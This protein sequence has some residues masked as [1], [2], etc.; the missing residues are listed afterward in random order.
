MSILANTRKTFGRLL[1][2]AAATASLTALAQDP[3]KAELEYYP[4]V[5]WNVGDHTME[6]GGVE[7]MPDGRVMIV[8]R[9]GEMF[10]A[11]NPMDAN[12]KVTYKPFA[13]G[14]AQPLGVAY[15][16][17][18]YYVAQRGE[19]TRIVD[20]DGDDR[21]DVFETVSDGWE[22][23]GSYHEYNFGPRMG[24][25]GQF[26]VTLNKPFGK[27]VYGR[28]RWRGWAVRVSLDG[29]M[30]GMAMGLRSPAGMEFSPWGELFYTDNQ[31]EWCNASKLSLIKKDDFHGHPHS[32]PDTAFADSPIRDV[33]Q[34]VSGTPMNDVA[35]QI[36]RWRM[37]AVWL[38]YR[39]IGQSPAG[40]AWDQSKG[41]FGPFQGQ[42]FVGDQHSSLLMRVALEKVN[43]HWQGAAFHHRKGLQC[44]VIRV[45]QLPDGSML[46]GQSERGWGALGAAPFGLQR[47]MWSGK[48]PFEMHEVKARPDGFEITFTQ[49]VSES[50]AKPESWKIKSYTYLLRKN[51]GGP[52]ENV[53][54]LTISSAKLAA[55]RKSVRLF[56][57]GLRQG[58]VHEIDGTGVVNDKGEKLLHPEAWYTLAEIP[59]E[60]ATL[61]FAG[62]KPTKGTADEPGA[63]EFATQNLPAGTRGGVKLTHQNGEF[64][65]GYQLGGKANVTIF[66]KPLDLTS[67]VMKI[68]GT[69]VQPSMKSVDPKGWNSVR[70]NYQRQGGKPMLSRVYINQRLIHQAVPLGSGTGRADVIIN[71]TGALKISDFTQ[72]ATQAEDVSTKPQAKPQQGGKKKPGNNKKQGPKKPATLKNGNLAHAESATITGDASFEPAADRQCVGMW[73]GKTAK[74]TWAKLPLKAG[75]YEV[76]LRQSLLGA[77]GAEVKIT[78]GDKTLTT[79]TKNNGD[80][81]TFVD[82]PAGK[83]FHKKDGPVDVT[84]QGT[85]FKGTYLFNLRGVVFNKAKK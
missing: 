77:D 15:H 28:A 41:K 66:G 76:K 8:T 85:K 40:M 64:A 19:L 65:F 3:P 22:I 57:D 21:A 10:I 68:N 72:R 30:E 34:P 71:A 13:F 74:A 53:Q 39:R 63:A 26:W 31:G 48:V 70:V 32:Q 42:L 44:G 81:G 49:P 55:D 52:D 69:P 11:E 33:P 78:I 67:G 18:A 59:G 73:K 79:K 56:V 58:Y 4:Q 83:Y 60:S 17:G 20:T 23:S 36:P 84:V 12:G 35:L 80:W 50:A 54:D 45:R 46:T 82:V 37:P 27:E 14:L 7:V 9:R 62:G 1:T 38:P 43:G 5:T 6:V 2:A 47:I 75:I 25:D 61:T 51:Y 24:P 29:K 16:D